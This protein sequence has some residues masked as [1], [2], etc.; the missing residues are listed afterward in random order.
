MA[1]DLLTE[2]RVLQESLIFFML[3]AITKLNQFKQNLSMSEK[4]QNQPG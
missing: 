4:N 1:T 3:C 2:N